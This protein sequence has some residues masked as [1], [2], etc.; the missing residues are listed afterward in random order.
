MG[1]KSYKKVFIKDPEM[2]E[3]EG[4]YMDLGIM[5]LKDFKLKSLEQIYGMKDEDYELL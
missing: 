2:P 4:E 5:Y 3:M 1:G